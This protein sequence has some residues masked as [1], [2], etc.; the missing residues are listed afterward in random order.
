MISRILAKIC[1]VK[2]YMMN[3]LM[4]LGNVIEAV[5]EWCMIVFTSDCMLI[6]LNAVYYVSLC[7]YTKRSKNP[8]AHIF[9][10]K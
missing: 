5:I 3:L 4:C 7:L 1:L 2:N 6:L 10:S 9:N 8:D